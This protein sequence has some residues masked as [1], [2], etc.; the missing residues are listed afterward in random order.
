MRHHSATQSSATRPQR[1]PPRPRPRPRLPPLPQQQQR[2]R[3]QRA[4]AGC[5]RQHRS[6]GSHARQRQRLHRPRHLRSAPTSTHPPWHR[7]CHVDRQES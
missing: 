1:P 7:H 4:W 3:R 2:R 6:Q 5:L